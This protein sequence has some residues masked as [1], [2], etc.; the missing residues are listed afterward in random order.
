VVRDLIALEEVEVEPDGERFLLHTEMGGGL[1]R[2]VYDIRRYFTPNYNA[3][4]K[5][6]NG[7]S[8]T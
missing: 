2:C 1:R 3:V 5:L 6:I 7:K 8:K 4:S